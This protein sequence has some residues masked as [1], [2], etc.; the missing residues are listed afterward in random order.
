[1]KFLT[2][3]LMV[4]PSFMHANT[5]VDCYQNEAVKSIRADLDEWNIK[6]WREYPYLYVFQDETNYNSIFE[7]DPEAFVLFAKRDGKMLG[8]L[9]ANP[10]DSSF[11]EQDHYTPHSQLEQ[12]R[13]KGFDPSKILYISCFL[14]MGEERSNLEAINQ[15]FDQAIE[16]AKKL[17]KIQICYMEIV[18]DEKHPLRPS[19]FVPL[20]PW[21]DLGKEFRSMDVT[22]E[23]NWPTLQPDGNVK[24]EAHQ[25][26]FYVMDL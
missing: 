7:D 18:E 10:L 12:I 21:N 17:G 6:L 15:L 26:A 8:F 16:Q 20:E 19:P 2:L 14:M 3:I 23:M 25:M 24:E 5:N 22:L 1:M 4:V 9:Q 11:L 13:K